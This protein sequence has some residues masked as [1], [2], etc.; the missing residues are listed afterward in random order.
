MAIVMRTLV[1]LFSSMG[2]RMALQ[3][4]SSGKSFVT[5]FKRTFEWFLSSVSSLVNLMRKTY[6]AILGV[7]VTSS[8]PCWMK[9]TK[10]FSLVSLVHSSNMAAKALFFISQGIPGHVLA[11][12]ELG[13]FFLRLQCDFEER[14]CERH[15]THPGYH[16]LYLKM[17][18]PMSNPPYPSRILASVP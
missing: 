15:P 5:I 4:I 18:H 14:I 3:T 9:I 10:H 1:R 12:Q 11:H 16:L 13:N 2:S 7:Q 17:T 8:P 6:L